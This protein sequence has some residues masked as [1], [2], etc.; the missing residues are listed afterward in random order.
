MGFVIIEC[1]SDECI[2]DQQIKETICNKKDSVYDESE[3][4]T[5]WVDDDEVKAYLEEYMHPKE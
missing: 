2:D 1:L 3:V 5:K 4:I